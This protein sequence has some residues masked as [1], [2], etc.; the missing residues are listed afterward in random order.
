MFLVHEIDSTNQHENRVN[1]RHNQ[2]VGK[3]LTQMICHPPLQRVAL[4]QQPPKSPS[5]PQSSD[6]SNQDPGEDRTPTASFTACL[7]LIFETA[8]FASSVFGTLAL[9]LNKQLTLYHYK[10]VLT[11]RRVL[12]QNATA[13]HFLAGIFSAKSDESFNGN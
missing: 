13:R 11:T 9:V 7:F 5:A 12:L 4:G 2:N 10:K 6:G 1:V 3:I 8:I